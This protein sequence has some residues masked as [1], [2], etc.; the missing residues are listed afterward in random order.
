MWNRGRKKELEVSRVFHSTNL[1][2]LIS[3]ALLRTRNCAQVDVCYMNKRANKWVIRVVEV[4]SSTLGKKYA[5]LKQ[6]HRL[7]RSALLLSTIFEAN[8]V[9]EYLS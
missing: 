4:K 6:D 1:P 9:I 8:I 3:P 2:I 5:K 7:R